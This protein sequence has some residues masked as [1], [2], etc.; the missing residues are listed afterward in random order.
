M[1]LSIN[2]KVKGAVFGYAVGDALGLGTEFM[3]R[4]EI[5]RKYPE[6]LS[7]YS[8][9]VRD[10]HRSMWVRGEYTNDTKI[11]ILLIRSM[12]EKKTVDCLDFAKRLADWYDTDP[13]DLTTNMRWVL[14]REE[15]ADN[16]FETAD[17]VWQL[18]N[19]DEAPSD[20]LGRALFTGLWNSDVAK[21]TRETCRLTHPNTRCLLNADIIATVANSLMWK[22]EMPPYEKLVDMAAKDDVDT[23]KY[24]DLARHGI[25]ADFCL[26]QESTYWYVRKALGAALWTLW[27][28]NSIEEGLLKV[29]NEGGDADTNASLAAGMLGLK[30]GYSAIPAKYV[31]GLIEK[32][33]LEKLCEE[34]VEVLTEKF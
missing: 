19:R 30:Y 4:K 31:D 7:E 21:N 26:D 9:I 14:S 18:M 25:L 1:N 15:F 13:V 11:I 29:V 34:F 22:E 24:L 8:Q 27:H 16:P 33:T 20:A 28:C 17:N 3:T 6:G 23:L 10:A 5:S 12:C 32:E 2:E